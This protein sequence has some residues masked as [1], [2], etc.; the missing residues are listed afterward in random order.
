MVRAAATVLRPGGRFYLVS[1]AF[2]RYER[3]MA[4]RFAG[5]EEVFNDRRYRVLRTLC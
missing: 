2:I 3:E 5:V 1:K 4:G